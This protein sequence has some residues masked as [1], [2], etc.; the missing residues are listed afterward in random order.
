MTASK[1]TRTAALK[2]ARDRETRSILPLTKK[3]EARFH[4]IQD[5]AAFAKDLDI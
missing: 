5:W 2:S 3:T 1:A 4:F